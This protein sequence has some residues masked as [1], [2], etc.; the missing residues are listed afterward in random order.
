MVELNSL[1][2]FWLKINF[3]KVIIEEVWQSI[4][5]YIVAIY[6]I[7]VDKIW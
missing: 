3:H 1:L 4:S 5:L 2:E 7:Q 6:Q